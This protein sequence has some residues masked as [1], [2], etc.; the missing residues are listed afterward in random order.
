VHDFVRALLQRFAAF[1]QLIGAPALGFAALIE[2]LA[3][4]QEIRKTR[5]HISDPSRFARAELGRNK[6]LALD[7]IAAVDPCEVNAIGVLHAVTLGIFW[8]RIQGG[9]KLRLDSMRTKKHMRAGWAN[10]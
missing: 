1:H 4:H 8:M 5:D 10:R 9:L 6:T 3:R 7:V 2:A